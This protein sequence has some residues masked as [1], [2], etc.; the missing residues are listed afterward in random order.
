[1]A[2]TRDIKWYRRWA[3]RV[4]E[5]SKQY[6]R[7]EAT[8]TELETTISKNP[9][10]IKTVTCEG[11]VATDVEYGFG[12]RK[13]NG[14]PAWMYPPQFMTLPQ[15]FFDDLAMTSEMVE[16]RNHSG[17]NEAQAR[18][19]VTKLLEAVYKELRLN[20]FAGPNDIRMLQET[21]FTFYP[22]K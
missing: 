9:S 16:P 18:T 1:M 11:L 17:E 5:R 20:G 14:R 19:M 8:L 3:Q 7:G 6:N 21:T 2:K 15:V 10:T 22:M 13:A 4:K 12:L